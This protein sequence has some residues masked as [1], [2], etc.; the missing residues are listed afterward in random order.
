MKKII[1]VSGKLQSGKNTFANFLGKRLSEI[2]FNVS[3]DLFAKDLK[4]NCKNDFKSLNIAINE[5]VQYIEELLKYLELSEYQ[6]V[7][8]SVKRQ[9]NEFKIVDENYYEDKTFITRCLLQIYGT[10]IFRNRVNENHWVDQVIERS[11]QSNTDFIIVTD[12]RFENE[13]DRVKELSNNEYEVITIRVERK[14]ERNSVMDLHPSENALD[15]YLTWDYIIDNN[16]SLENLIESANTI[17]DY[18]KK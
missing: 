8:D 12:V 3:E 1:L 4:N 7:V 16:S 17:I 2:G 9:L 10:E 5:K 15:D 6:N 14:L 11:K 18:L 13:I